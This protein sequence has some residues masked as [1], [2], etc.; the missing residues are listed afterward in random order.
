MRLLF[1]PTSPY[2]AKVRM[3]A[4]ALK[5]NVVAER[6][7]TSADPDILISNNPLGKIPVLLTDDGLAVYDSRAIMLYLDRLSG[8]RVFPGDSTAK[9]EAQVLEATAD[10]ITD[11]LLAIVYERRFHP[12]EKVHE[13]WIERQKSKAARGLEHLS[14]MNLDISNGL[15]GGHFAV[16]ALLGYLE[17]R[18]PGEFDLGNPSIKTFVASFTEAFPDYPAMKPQ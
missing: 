11:C 4:H 12:P 6:V 1:S 7:D 5:L 8:G 16:A 9:T 13:P 15:N 14:T 2:S 10:G 3:T 17:L 18:F